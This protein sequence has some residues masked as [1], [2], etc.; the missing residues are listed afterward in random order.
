MK[1]TPETKKQKRKHPIRRA[2]ALCILAAA[3]AAGAVYTH[4]GGFGTGDCADTDEFAKYACGIDDMTIPADAKMIALGEATH[5]NAEF[6]RLKLDVFK[7]AVSENGVRAFCL[8]GDCG[9]CEAVN[10]YIHGGEGTP[11]QAAAAIGFEIYRTDETAQLISWMREYNQSA[12]PGDDLRFCG[13]DMQRTDYNYKYLLEV[14]EN[15]NADTTGLKKL[16]DGDG[17]SDSFDADERASVIGG[18]KVQLEELGDAEGAHFAEI[19]LQNIEL[20]KVIDTTND[21]TILRD[22]YMAQNA[23]WIS[24]REAQ[25]GNDAIFLSGHNGHMTQFGSYTVEDKVMGNILADEL[26]DAYFVIGTDFYKSKCDLP[27]GKERRRVGH[28][29]Y[30]Y[31]PLAKAAKKCG[32]DECWLNFSDVPETSALNESISE[33]TWMCSLGDVPY[34]ALMRLLP[35]TYRIWRSPATMYDAMIFVS[36]AHPTVIAPAE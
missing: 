29:F 7:K 20:A 27:T 36:D 16:W 28:T 1:K 22:R 9:G 6:Q 32:F 23:M 18:V 8:E 25:R 17:Y 4:F 15:A 3:I 31:D 19:L 10:R 33:Y 24:E 2:V 11:E 14:A 5:G 35:R 21:Y 34:S 26:S 30:S 12:A 13:F